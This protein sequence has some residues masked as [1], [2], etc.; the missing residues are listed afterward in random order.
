MEAAL[1]RA[2][3]PEI[4]TLQRDEDEIHL[5]AT[6]DETNGG[7]QWNVHP[8]PPHWRTKD[9]IVPMLNDSHRYELYQQAI[10]QMTIKSPQ[11]ALDIG[12]GTGVLAVLLAEKFPD[13]HISAVEMDNHMAELAKER[14]PQSVNLISQ[15]STELPPANAHI[16]TSEL[17]EDGLLGEG[18]ITTMR[19]AWKRHLTPDA[20]V[21]PQKARV[22]AQ[23][24]DCPKYMVGD[25]VFTD[26]SSPICL[27]V[28]A[29][30]LDIEY[31]TEAPLLIFEISVA[32]LEELPPELVTVSR[33]LSVHGRVTGILV[34]W[35]LDLAEGISYSMSPHTNTPFQNHWHQMLHTL[36]QPIAE[37]TE[38]RELV[39]T[40]SHDDVRIRIDLVPQNSA[41]GVAVPPKR[42]KASPNRRSPHREWQLRDGRYLN[43][44]RRGIEFVANQL[45]PESV[46]LDASDYG[47]VAMML[48]FVAPTTRILS[49][50]TSLSD[51]LPLEAARIA[52]ANNLSLELLR[53]HWEDLSLSAIGGKPVDAIVAEPY[54]QVLEDWPILQAFNLYCI[55][56]GLVRRQLVASQAQILPAKAR[57]VAVAMECEQIRSA[58]GPIAHNHEC[59][60]KRVDFSKFDLSLDLDHFVTK[61]LT[62]PWIVTELDYVGLLN[63]APHGVVRKLSTECLSTH[64]GT[65]DLIA[66]KIEYLV[67]D[68][69]WCESPRQAVRLLHKPIRLD[70]QHCAI[71][72][73]CQFG[74]LGEFESHS[75]D[76]RVLERRS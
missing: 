70:D 15:H 57:I 29:R 56:R 16:C 5:I 45:P 20:I 41:T 24:V 36:S 63:K 30:N 58:Y 7:I 71:E 6:I 13:L 21:V 19:D 69:M 34:W 33:S 17:L 12:T 61:D 4:V 48:A 28:H 54:F 76:I 51:E 62:K 52:Q 42:F 66:F 2:K 32:K 8:N 27:P 72:C 73:Q 53:C 60:N 49:V 10:Q 46:V 55:I 26:C 74:G 68:D 18:W 38:E 1:G 23:P 35:E 11:R 47:L 75:F 50:E 39:M 67:G 31:R 14:L 3:Y 64:S 25:S 22:F 37:E 40:A 59:V 44:W 43:T 65:I 9:W